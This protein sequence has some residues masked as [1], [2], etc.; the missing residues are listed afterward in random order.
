MLLAAVLSAQGAPAAFAAGSA[1]TAYYTFSAAG[2]KQYLT[3]AMDDG[4]T[5]K[6]VTRDGR[7]GWEISNANDTTESATINIGVDSSFA[8]DI[9]D[10]S[11]FEIEID[12]YD[13]GKAVFSLVYSARDRSDRF[14]GSVMTDGV[15]SK[16]VANDI[17]Q[18]KTATFRIQDARFNDSLD[19]ADFKLSANILNSNHGISSSTPNGYG[20][21]YSSYYP[22]TYGRVSTVDPIVLGEVRV[23]K[24]ESKNP[25]D[26]KVTMDTTSNTLFDEESAKF[27]Y[28]FSNGTAEP[29][30]LDA[31][32]IVTDQDGREVLTKS[33]TLEIAANEK[34]EF[35]VDLGQVPYGLFTLTSVFTADGVEN[36][37]ETEF[38]HSREA[39]VPN[40]SVGT[41]VHFEGSDS[42]KN[43]ENKIMELVKKAGIGSVRDSI[44]W[45]DIELTK[46]RYEIP[47]M[48]LRGME[49]A[50]NMGIEYFP[51]ITG[52]NPNVYGEA[53]QPPKDEA[54]LA[55]YE[56]F[57][58]YVAGEF[59]GIATAAETWN[60]YNI[61]YPAHTAEEMT[62]MI[63]ATYDGV[64]A[65]AP[66]M[67]VI[68]IDD[69][70]LSL[71]DMRKLFEA[72]ALDY[73]DGISYHPYYH[74]RGPET[75]GV[76]SNGLAVQ[77]L[78]A[79][80][81]KPEAEIWVTENGWPTWL[82]NPISDTDQAV[83]HVTT[84]LEN[85]AWQIFDRYYFYEFA[86]SGIQ[87]EYMESFFGMTKSVYDEVPYAARPSYVGVCNVNY[88]LG[89]TEFRDALGGLSMTADDFVYRFTRQNDDGK[90]SELIAIWTKGDRSE[91][92]LDLGCDSVTMYDFYGNESTLYG[93]DGKYSIAVTDVPVYLVG[94]FASFAECEPPIKADSLILGGATE[95]T[96]E[97]TITMKDSEGAYIVPEGSTYFDFAERTEFED[98]KAVLVVNTPEERF[99]NKCAQ[100][101]IEKDGK[102]YYHGNLKV[103]SVE[104]V[105]VNVDHQVSGSDVNRW[106]IAVDITNNRNS[107]SVNGR[108]Q[109][110]EPKELV[111]NM[112]TI[113]VTDLKPQET[114]TYR[115]F[116]PEVVT[117]EMRDFSM[118]TILSTGETFNITNKMFF[119]VVP[120][121]DGE[122][123][124]IDGNVSPGEYSEDTWLSIKGGEHGENVML[125]TEDT[126]YKGDSD[127]SGKA[128]MK[129]D[130]DN[131]YMFIEV[132]DNI[133]CNNN[134]DS[135][136]WSGDS[137][138]L[139]IAGEGA[140]SGGNYCEFTIALT[141]NGPE[142][143]RNLSN[144]A[145]SVGAVDTV[146]LQIV[147]DGTQTRYEMAL[148]WEEILP[149]GEVPKSGYRPRFAILI[150]EDDGLGRNSYLEYS[151]VLGAIGT[152]KNVGYFTD[153]YLTD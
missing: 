110:N 115:M 95:D 59:R 28:D 3:A 71:S 9:D 77:N 47:E 132:T 65:A 46:G 134:S 103:T 80:Y 130:E 56:K 11:V 129:Y 137:V 145:K 122:R 99:F 8:Y 153:M 22:D 121:A 37:T 90:G 88:Q 124:V 15:G 142:V 32:Y 141:P 30:S 148:P 58:E 82:G 67:K 51:I 19:T 125:L 78:L 139:G 41:N 1:D 10:G 81:G 38:S 64:K 68:G 94:D 60:E 116:M 35:S 106:Q 5:P 23:K 42:Y 36:K 61:H 62:A 147:R 135:M 118:D 44:R 84:I 66:E 52:D 140:A 151:Q 91:L 96:V 7:E 17:Q 26:V 108:I 69:A 24:L 114:R 144:N 25:F 136:S 93:V 149:E 138:Q 104:T 45:A 54:T 14:A 131:L 119:T 63:K 31:R 48:T 98:G 92:G 126:S 55:A 109:L 53:S 150:N 100:Y 76:F 113:Y 111:G 57:A 89:N 120:Y 72:G 128:T 20:S 12:Y 74:S 73:M 117:K 123:P 83:F 85:A 86:N 4:S 40:M 29:Y 34:K 112:A 2:E 13:A 50:E 49:L 127:L 102:I 79:E 16:E 107:T 70:G 21:Y 18:W 146:E 27:N 33:D 6:I 143:Y 105:T 97:Q 152:A 101:R 133:F 75:S 87:P 39:K 43:D